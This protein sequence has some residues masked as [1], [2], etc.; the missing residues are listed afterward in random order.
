MIIK[1]LD[2]AAMGY[3][4]S[5]EELKKFGDVVIYDNTSADELQKRAADAEVLV[6]NKVKIG[7]E[8]L[9]DAKKL[10]LGDAL[11]ASS[12]YIASFPLEYRPENQISE[13][14]HRH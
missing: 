5:F 11:A 1:V 2:R 12:T 6:I 3:D 10:K 4:L 7:R 14:R 8:F 13:Y 9:A